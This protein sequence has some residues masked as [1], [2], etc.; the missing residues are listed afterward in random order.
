MPHWEDF[1]TCTEALRRAGVEDG[2]PDATTV[3]VTLGSADADANHWGHGTNVYYGID[4][5]G[6]CQ[7]P[8]GGGRIQI[9]PVPT[10][11]CNEGTWGTVIDAHSGEFIVGGS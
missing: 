9:S 8:I 2:H 6:V 1:I 7:F 5:G 10:E 11:S 4:W 3:Q